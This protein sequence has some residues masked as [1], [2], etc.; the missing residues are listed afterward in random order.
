MLLNTPTTG[1]LQLFQRVAGD[2]LLVAGTN[3]LPP[4]ARGALHRLEARFAGTA[5]EAVLDNVVI[6]TATMSAY[7]TATRHGVLWHVGSDSSATF[8]N[9]AVTPPA[10]DTTVPVVTITTPTAAVTAGTNTAAMTLGGTASDGGGVTRVTWTNN[11]GGSGTATGTTSWSAMLTLQPGV[12]V[13]TVTARDAENNTA[14]DTLT[15]T[16]DVSAPVVTLTTPTAAATFETTTISGLP[17]TLQR[18]PKILYS[19]SPKRRV[20]ATCCLA[21]IF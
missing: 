4:G 11:R 19:I 20:N 14:S 15:V 6:F 10:V 21:P 3:T 8:D 1:M 9:F 2:F 16:L 5:I 13:L 12:N 17:D 7:Q 18:S